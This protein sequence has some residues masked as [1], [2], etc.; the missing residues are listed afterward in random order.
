MEIDLDAAL[1]PG[2]GAAGLTIGQPTKSLLEVAVP[3]SVEQRTGLLV[4]KYGPVWLFDK[5][6]RIDQIC[7][8]SGY[9]GRLAGTIGI[10]SLVAEVEAA[11]GPLEDLEWGEYGASGMPGWCFAVEAGNPAMN[12]PGWS[13]SKLASICIFADGF[14][15]DIAAKL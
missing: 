1:V 7:V 6:G 10:G 12:S 4:L 9:R 2:V 3:D 13:S 15:V 11:F 5:D 14:K 8:F